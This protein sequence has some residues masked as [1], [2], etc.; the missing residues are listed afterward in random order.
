MRL[1][2]LF[3]YS[4]VFLTTLIS[5]GQ[6]EKNFKVLNDFPD[7]ENIVEHFLKYHKI[8]VSQEENFYQFRFMRKPEGWF[9]IPEF[10]NLS[11]NTT[12][13][14]IEIWKNKSGFIIHPSKNPTEISLP[15]QF[16]LVLNNNARYDFVIHPFYGYIGW[17]EDVIDYFKKIKPSQM[18]NHE[19]YGLS[20]AYSHRAS[21]I[22]WAHSFFSD[23]SLVRSSKA[24]RSD[25]RKYLRLSYKSIEH[26][27]ELYM[28]NPDYKTLVGLLDIKL[29]NQIM[30]NWYELSLFG[31][32]KKADK[33][34]KK[35][36]PHYNEFWAKSSEYLLENL[37]ENAIFFT[38][39]DND[40]YPHLWNQ[41]TKNI[42]KDVLIINSSLLND[43]EYFS[44]LCD[45]GQKSN[46]LTSGLN[47]EELKNLENKHII[48]INDTAK[49]QLSYAETENYV[50]QQ[51]YTHNNTILMEYGYYSIPFLNEKLEP[52]TLVMLNA[53]KRQISFQQFLLTGIMYHNIGLR[54]IY[55]M[56][57]MI[58]DFQKLFN[59]SSLLD[60]GM[61]IRLTNKA[62]NYS[63]YYYSYYDSDKVAALLKASP[64]NLP[65]KKYP[66]RQKF[67]QLF[68]EM[69]S[70]AISYDID[71]NN[72]EKKHQQ[73]LDYLKQYP[74][75]IAGLSL[76]YYNLIYTLFQA[77]L[78]KELAQMFLKAFLVELENEIRDT[79]LIDS[80][81]N[82]YDYLRSLSYIISSIIRS[83]LDPDI[84]NFY[85]N[86]FILEKSINKKLRQIPE[87]KFD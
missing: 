81:P 40:T 66:S 73:I 61:V 52:D 60:E 63:D 84:P 4:S 19:L 67:Y 46:P 35:T 48:A 39:G 79:E 15:E 6:E 86:L 82:D 77:D 85:E 87:V 21:N 14:E 36:Q 18:S 30:A 56:K 20:R 12:R 49:L 29:A 55:F 65:N 25:I 58:P 34:I 41:A 71:D 43:V 69:E 13:K 70:R 31:H 1:K 64:V 59:P 83:E 54:P 74:Q 45:N 9:V 53:T 42:R 3:L 72:S 16:A 26:L 37:E 22:F 44:L 50:R 32:Y 10:Y 68:L 17:D 75:N 23:V 47:K 11:G 5:Q 24:K 62:N 8:S 33:F 38:I 7:Y 57:S 51:S 2:L 80:D 76:H 28:R 27:K 78:N